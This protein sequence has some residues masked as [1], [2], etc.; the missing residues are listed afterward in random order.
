MTVSDSSPTVSSSAAAPRGLDH[1]P[2]HLLSEMMTNIGVSVADLSKK[3][4]VLLIFLRYFGCVFCQRNIVEVVN[5]LSSLIKFNCVPV[6]VHQESEEEANKFFSEEGMPQPLKVADHEEEK[7]QNSHR[8]S[9]GS[10]HDEENTLN[11]NGK[12]S[13]RLTHLPL[14]SR[15]ELMKKF[16]RVSDPEGN[17]YYQKFGIKTSSMSD[18]S[19][20][21][22]TILETIRLSVTQGYKMSSNLSE[23]ASRTQLAATF[24]V[25]HGKIVNQYFNETAYVVPDVLEILL[26]LEG[27][28][29]D[30]VFELLQ[31]VEEEKVTSDLEENKVCSFMDASSH[32]KEHEDQSIS[33]SKKASPSMVSHIKE[34]EQNFPTA[35]NILGG[36]NPSFT[37]MT[38][39]TTTGTARTTT[40]MTTTN[41]NKK[42]YKTNKESSSSCLFRGS[43]NRNSTQ[44]DPSKLL[45]LEKVLLN[46]DY[47]KVFKL[48]AAKLYAVE[49]LLFWEQA[50]RYQNTSNEK[51]REK[52]ARVII[53]TYLDPNSPL[54]IN[55]SSTMK[56]LVLNR[57]EK[58]GCVIHL[59]DELIRNMESDSIMDTYLRFLESDLCKEKILKNKLNKT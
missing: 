54:E 23:R 43:H 56:H 7:L 27:K 44:M 33:T 21:I 14:H 40:T 16:L 22:K 31:H 11:N 5:C 34:L 6:F 30:N 4:V 32:T 25:A 18:F 13:H 9:A 42:K 48:F 3:H 1:A 58:E 49:S 55:T 17:Y 19:G 46:D 38:T 53:D 35:K 45:T 28:S 36:T 51:T 50:T 57:Y 24:V 37:T 41:T 52:A 15:A 39:A 8:S 20:N 10:I 47:R 29:S 26:D 12:E 2:H 59:F